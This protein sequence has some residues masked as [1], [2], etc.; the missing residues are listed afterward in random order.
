VKR[1]KSEKDVRRSLEKG[2]L[3]NLVRAMTGI[4]RAHDR[5]NSEQK[6]KSQAACCQNGQVGLSPWFL[7]NANQG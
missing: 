5:T 6:I 1:R 4:G 2:S 3:I 7:V